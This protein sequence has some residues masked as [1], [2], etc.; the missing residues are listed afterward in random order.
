[1]Q[2]TTGFNLARVVKDVREL[3]CP[4]GGIYAKA[5]NNDDYSMIYVM[6]VGAEGTPY[7]G[8]L[9]YFTVEPG[10]D[11][12]HNAGSNLKY[13]FN[14]P[15]VLF[16][17]GYKGYIHT[18]L[19][20]PESGGKV[21]L[22]ILYGTTDSNEKWIPTMS[23][24]TIFQTI[25]GILDLATNDSF[26]TGAKMH[27]RP[28]DMK[29]TITRD[30]IVENIIPAIQGKSKPI[31]IQWPDTDPINFGELFQNEIREVFTR[32]YAK[33]CLQVK[34]IG[35]WLKSQAM[36]NKKTAR[37][38]DIYDMN[39]N[40]RKIDTEALM[41]LLEQHKPF[42]AVE[43][44]PQTPQ[45]TIKSAETPAATSKL[46]KVPAT[47]AEKS[48][49]VIVKPMVAKKPAAVAEKPTVVE[50]LP[51][52]KG[53]KKSREL[54]VSSSIPTITSVAK[55]I[56]EADKIA[57]PITVEQLDEKHGS[58]LDDILDEDIADD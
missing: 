22:S 29:C 9:F 28:W 6:L 51:A 56:V 3:H 23:F 21:C 35:N 25:F 1:M 5:R 26:Y 40:T 11:W 49:T 32:R 24:N 18:N 15:R 57:K 7:E 2:N 4:D 13:P 38:M 55:G 36:K 30:T 37:E 8:G 12:L 16:Y 34:N 31:A 41:K 20:T 10:R 50:K 48:V 54:K 58:I 53:K 46:E 52:T 44:V 42:G 33:Y 43:T 47:V 45:A 17:S 14:S 39:G 27:A 19:Y